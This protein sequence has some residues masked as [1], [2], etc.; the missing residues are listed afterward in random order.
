MSLAPALHLRHPQVPLL[1][2]PAKLRWVPIHSLQSPEE[3]THRQ[4][5]ILLNLS[6]LASTQHSIEGRTIRVHISQ[7][8][9]LG[10]IPL[11]LTTAIH[12]GGPAGEMTLHHWVPISHHSPHNPDT[13]A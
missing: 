8:K 1:I 5:P 11:T 6:I 13:A 10:T 12:T 7:H 3:N 2:P 4:D 9:A